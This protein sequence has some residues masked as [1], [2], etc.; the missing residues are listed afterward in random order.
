MAIVQISKIIH[1]VGANVDL[2][3]LD[4][5]EIG[6]ASDIQKVYIG[7]DPVLVPV[8][9]GAI[10]TQTEILTE[11]STLQFAKLEGSNN[12]SLTLDAVVT[13]QL[14]VA[15]GNATTGT[16]WTNWDGTLLGTSKNL[17][18]TLGAPA[19]IS[20][21][22][23]GSGQFLS[24]DGTG[25][26]TWRN[27]SGASLGVGDAVGWLHNNGTGTLAW[28]SPTNV[29]YGTSN[30]AVI[31]N[32]NV[33][34]SVGGTANIATFTTANI[35]LSAN[36]DIK[37]SGTASEVSGANLVSGTYLAGTVTTVYQPNITGVGT[38]ANLTVT[39][40]ATVG[41]LIVTVATAPTTSHGSPGDK[42]GQIAFDTNY[43]YYCRANYVDTSTDIWSRVAMSQ[44]AF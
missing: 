29:Y 2:P 42:K 23:G 21:T 30:V 43:M 35:T 24:T 27:A 32:G 31:N 9:D 3:Q 1:R 5:G 41:T 34:V 12:T 20:I 28:T 8:P 10:T 33:T 6:F 39:G 13:G 16:S 15:N 11:V 44:T 40:N 7:N 4:T 19:N 36:T 14:L 25:N 38:L 22:G 17:K 18:L 37:L 26:L